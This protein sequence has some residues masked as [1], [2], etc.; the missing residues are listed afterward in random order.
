M[1][2]G[3][4]ARRLFAGVLRTPMELGDR[5][6]E[7]RLERFITVAAA[8]A[9]VFPE[10]PTGQPAAGTGPFAFVLFATCGSCRKQVFFRI[11]EIAEVA[12]KFSE[13]QAIEEFRANILLFGAGITQVQGFHLPVDL[14]LNMDGGNVFIAHHA[15]HGKSRV[16][17]PEV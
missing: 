1:T 14:I 13:G 7:N 8:E 5:L 9:T 16:V 2:R 4:V 10:L 11:H 3:G 12:E 17:Y 6:M 15:L